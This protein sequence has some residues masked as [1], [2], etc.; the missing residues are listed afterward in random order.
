MATIEVDFDVFKE[1]TARRESELMTENDVI[2][3]LLGFE[4]IV[5]KKQPLSNPKQ[6]AWITKGTNFPH[7]TEFKAMYKGHQYIGVVDNGGLLINEKKFT[8]ASAAAME[9]TGNPVNGW[10]FWECHLPGTNIWQ[11]I[12]NLR[13]YSN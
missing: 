6:R 9:I 3:K 5:S 4:M 10:K 11:V 2:R 12:A 13:K 8:S 1:L 7:G